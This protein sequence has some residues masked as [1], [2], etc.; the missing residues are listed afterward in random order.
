MTP[1]LAEESL[2]TDADGLKAHMADLE[3]DMERMQG[4]IKTLMAEEDGAAGICHAAAIHEA[5]QTFMMLRYQR[6]LCAARLGRLAQG[7]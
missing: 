6:D 3:A 4:T 5:K 7:F 1:L 2:P